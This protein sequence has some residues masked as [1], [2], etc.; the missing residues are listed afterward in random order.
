MAFSCGFSRPIRSRCSRVS[1]TEEI[2]FACSA[3]DSSVRVELI[4]YSMTFGTR[5]RPSCTEGATAW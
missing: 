1:S 3:P 2:F 4:T 5:Y